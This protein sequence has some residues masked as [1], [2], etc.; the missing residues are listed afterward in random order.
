MRVEEVCF[1]TLDSAAPYYGING[2]K[3][4]VGGG[5]LQV[6]HVPTGNI[7]LNYIP[8]FDT[9]LHYPPCLSKFNILFITCCSFQNVDRTRET[10]W[11]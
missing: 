10:S 11:N 8:S 7:G 2:G 4:N 5:G 6:L 3:S 1:Q 9:F